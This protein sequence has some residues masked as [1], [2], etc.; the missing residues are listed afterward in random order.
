MIPDRHGSR[1]L[2]P[3]PAEPPAAPSIAS[4]GRQ[5]ADVRDRRVRRRTP[6]EAAASAPTSSVVAPSIAAATAGR[7]RPS[8]ATASR[9][10]TPGTAKSRA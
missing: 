3:R 5:L 4:G 6:R 10:S 2:G 7:A 8:I 9:G 1:R